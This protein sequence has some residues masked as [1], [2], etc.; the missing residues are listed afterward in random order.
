M[1]FALRK[2]VKYQG[3]LNLK[4]NLETHE[5]SGPQNTSSQVPDRT[6]SIASVP[7]LANARAVSS[8]SVPAA[9]P[10]SVDTSVSS[11]TP[12]QQMAHVFLGL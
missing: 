4:E 5:E 11:S 12:L 2:R 1:K 8:S 10:A 9:A 7:G 3:F 6:D